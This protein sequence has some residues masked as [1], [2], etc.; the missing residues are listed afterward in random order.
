MQKYLGVPSMC[1]VLFV[2]LVLAWILPIIASF[3]LSLPSRLHGTVHNI[4]HAIYGHDEYEYDTKLK[5]MDDGNVHLIILHDVSWLSWMSSWILTYV[6]QLSMNSK[7]SRIFSIVLGLIMLIG[8]GSVGSEP[9]MPVMILFP[10]AYGVVNGRLLPLAGVLPYTIGTIC[11]VLMTLTDVLA[12]R[13]NSEMTVKWIKKRR[14]SWR[15]C[16]NCPVYNVLSLS[17]LLRVLILLLWQWFMVYN[18]YFAYGVKGMMTSPYGITTSV[19]S[20]IVILMV[21]I[22]EVRQLIR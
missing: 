2:F 18:L 14:L 15:H 17:C 16:V 19:I 22:K 3:L 11:C 21:Y 10:W 9:G 8:P 5:S 4:H 7:R 20:V 12:I 13:S 6:W 1:S